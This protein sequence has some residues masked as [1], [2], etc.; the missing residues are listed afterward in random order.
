MGSD[1]A[2]RCRGCDEGIKPSHTHGKRKWFF[3]FKALLD[4]GTYWIGLEMQL[5]HLI[6]YE[7]C[8]L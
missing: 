3:F 2:P 5:M 8:Q 4:S 6:E 7:L 1:K